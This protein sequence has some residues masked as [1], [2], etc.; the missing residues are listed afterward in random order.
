MANLNNKGA[1]NSDQSKKPSSFFEK[2]G[3][4]ISTI[5]DDITDNIERRKQL[6]NPPSNITNNQLQFIYRPNQ[7][8]EDSIKIETKPLTPTEGTHRQISGKKK[9]KF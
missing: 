6:H 5:K 9:K 1:M 2:V 7:T 8:E 4:K 3:Q